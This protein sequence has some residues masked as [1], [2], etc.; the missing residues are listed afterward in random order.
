MATVIRNCKNLLASEERAFL[1]IDVIMT[2]PRMFGIHYSIRKC[3]QRDVVDSEGRRGC[4]AVTSLRGMSRTCFRYRFKRE[5]RVETMPRIGGSTRRRKRN[6][7]KGVPHVWHKI[8]EKCTHHKL[9]KKY[10]F[11]AFNNNVCPR[12][13]QK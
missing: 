4:G 1:N 3:T 12:Q 8:R 11:S 7:A 13:R 2:S 10:S 5:P 9:P 6:S